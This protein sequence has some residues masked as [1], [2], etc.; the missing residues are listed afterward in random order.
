[1]HRAAIG[2]FFNTVLEN[3]LSSSFT[4]FPNLVV[5]ASAEALFTFC[6]GGCLR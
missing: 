3:L 5:G 1:M 4:S 2:L 6:F